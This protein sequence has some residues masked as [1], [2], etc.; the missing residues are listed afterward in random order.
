MK[1]SQIMAGFVAS[2]EISD[3]PILEKVYKKFPHFSKEQIKNYLLIPNR[4]PP[5]LKELEINGHIAPN[6]KLSIII[7]IFATDYYEWEEKKNSE[8]KITELALAISE[9]LR[10]HR[11]LLDSFKVN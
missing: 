3:R 10:K 4:L 11:T 7:A 6:P 9:Y 8:G 1:F 5:S 2:E